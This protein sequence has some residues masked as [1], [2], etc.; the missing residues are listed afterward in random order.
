[1][2]NDH[3][4]KK[5]VNLQ[6]NLNGASAE[7]LIEQFMEISEKARECIVAIQNSM[8]HGRDY[9]TMPD[10]EAYKQD[11]EVCYEMLQNLDRINDY[12]QECAMH[13]HRQKKE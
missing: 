4:S 7:S 13:V 5:H 2:S 1:M 9:Q 12:A 6:L 3:L 8:P 11:R 10:D